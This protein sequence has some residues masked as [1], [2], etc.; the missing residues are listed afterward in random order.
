MRRLP[1]ILL[2]AATAVSLPIATAA[3]CA[4]QYARPDY[5]ADPPVALRA[6]MREDFARTQVRNFRDAGFRPANEWSGR[7]RAAIV[8]VLPTLRSALGARWDGALPLYQVVATGGVFHVSVACFE[9]G[10]DGGTLSPVS[11]TASFE[12][13]ADYTVVRMLGTL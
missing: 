2:N 9:R 11:P 12:V 1:R 4:T 5:P 10:P 3:G 13:S 7:E 6:R 8:A